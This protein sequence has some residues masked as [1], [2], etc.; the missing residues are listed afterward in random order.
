LEEFFMKKTWL[1]AL[2]GMLFFAGMAFSQGVPLAGEWVTYTDA[3]D[4]GDSTIT[5]TQV[6]VDGQAATNYTGKITAKAQYGFAGWELKPDAATLTAIR[7]LRPT[8]TLTFKVKGDG[9]KYTVELRSSRV[10]DY[11]YHA[12][13]ITT[14]AGQTQTVTIQVRQFLQPGWGASVGPLAPATIEVVAFQTHESLRQGKDV[15]YDITIW[16][17]RLNP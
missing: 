17:I 15:P 16:D 3:N 5:V 4:G 9:Q 13:N 8:S 11:G 12:Y 6:T 1:L 14:Q 2:A 10:K 7:A